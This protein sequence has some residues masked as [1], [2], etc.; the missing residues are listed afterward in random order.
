MLAFA[1][2][3]SSPKPRLFSASVRSSAEPIDCEWKEL[4]FETRGELEELEEFDPR[5]KF[6]CGYSSSSES[7]TVSS[8]SLR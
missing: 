4:L 8:S 5:P 7:K 6:L 2:G 3:S 1:G